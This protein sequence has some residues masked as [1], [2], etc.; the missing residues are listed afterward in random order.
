MAHIV[1][2]TNALSTNPNFTSTHLCVVESKNDVDFL[3]N[4]AT[5]YGPFGSE[6]DAEAF[7]DD[8]SCG[9]YITVPMTTTC[10]DNTF[11]SVGFSRNSGVCI[12]AAL[13]GKNYLS[14]GSHFVGPFTTNDEARAWAKEHITDTPYDNPYWEVIP[15]QVILD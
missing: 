3:T 5:V 15:M 6:S 9:L 10:P 4:G 1:H 12:I 14:G 13:N 11:K 7:I 8:S 2:D